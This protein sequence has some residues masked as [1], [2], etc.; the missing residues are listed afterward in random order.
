MDRLNQRI[1]VAQLALQKLTD[2]L[3]HDPMS[4]IV[5]DAAIQRF[6]YSFEATWKALQAWLKKH[7][8]ILA[9]SPKSVFRAFF[10]AQLID[11]AQA[12]MALVMVDDRNLT[13][14]T[15]NEELANRIFQALGAYQTL[16]S[17]CIQGV[18]SVPPTN[19]ERDRGN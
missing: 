9:A 8:G 7:E 5:R 17:T 10:Q 12:R 15:C 3:R 4:S 16:M 1:H 13:T 18:Q 11:E 6:K 2:V 14:H 19:N